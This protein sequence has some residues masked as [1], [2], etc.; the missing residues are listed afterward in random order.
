MQLR[1]RRP[2]PR[3]TRLTRASDFAAAR[4][5]GRTWSDR[6]LVLVA[7]RN[8][9]DVSRVGFSVGRR[10]G[11]AVVRNR[12]KR[13]LREAVRLTPAQGGWDLVIIAR[14][15]AASAGFGR[16]SRSVTDLFERAGVLSD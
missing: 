2:M 8:Q 5:H 12:T 14:R 7:R 1:A 10:V 16:L 4:R 15:D 9:R 13:R 11:N 3:D 6:W